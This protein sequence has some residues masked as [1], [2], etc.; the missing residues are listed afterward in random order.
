MRILGLVSVFAT[1]LS[2][3]ACSAGVDVDHEDLEATERRRADA[4]AAS[5]DSGMPRDAGGS[6]DAEAVQD[7]DAAAVNDAGPRSAP[8][9]LRIHITGFEAYVGKTLVIGVVA[10][11]PATVSKQLRVPSA[12]F[13][14]LLEG[15]N[16]FVFY[17]ALR[18]AVDTDEDR[19]CEASD[20]L[21]WKDVPLQSNDVQLDLSPAAL[22]TPTGSDLAE[23]CRDLG[24]GVN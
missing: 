5:H 20:F 10:G 14:V 23:H 2:F 1:L 9:D 24:I 19:T 13:D 8:F 12:T 11:A 16:P 3:V 18:L 6:R 7:A 17:Q 4:G 15:G 21:G 22:F